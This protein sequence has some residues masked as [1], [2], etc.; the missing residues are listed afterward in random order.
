MEGV[1]LDESTHQPVASAIITA[2]G[3]AYRTDLKG[4]YHIPN[5]ESIGVRAVG[6][7]RIFTRFQRK[8]YLR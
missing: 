2:N 1:I 3:K 6:Y 7:E 5:T 4:R 8:I